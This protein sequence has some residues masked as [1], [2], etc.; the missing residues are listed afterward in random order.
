MTDWNQIEYF[1]A[2]D[3]ASD[4]HDVVV[5]NKLG[6]I[7]VDFRFEHSGP[8]WEQFKE[9][10]RPFLG[11]PVA[12]ETNNGPAVDQLLAG[13]WSVYPVN[14]QSAERYRDRKLPSGTKTDHFDG[15]SLADALRTDGRG[16]KALAA[17]DPLLVELRLLCHDE[18]A[19]IEQRTGLINQLRAALREYYPAALEAFEDWTLPS[20]W[21][22][23]LAFP[24]P[25]KLPTAGRRHWEKFLHTHKLW[26]TQTV[27]QRLEIFGRATAFSGSVPI[28]AAKSLLACSVAR[29]LQTL[30]TQLQSFRLRIQALFAQHPDHDLFGSLPGA[31]IKIAPRLLA[32]L[33]D[34]RQQF[35]D[36]QSLQC[37]AG[38]APMS[39]E[40][41]QIKKARLRQACNDFLRSTIH[42]W[43]NLSRRQCPWAQ[44]YYQAH[45]AKGKSHACALRCL[46]QR[47]LK[48]LWRMWQNKTCYSPELH[49]KNQLAHGSWVLQLI[50]PK[51]SQ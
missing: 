40:S 14:P 18:V 8:G 2:L 33:G 25:H 48:I 32:G 44:A 7:V 51:P 28:V 29:L 46:G 21:A 9:Q 27:E 23:I 17:Q 37:H 16:W 6:Q 39:F 13:D 4:H 5:V 1:A 22:F 26:R 20:A 3:W 34:N 30:E 41:G 36:A 11:A 42:L 31:G 35:P 38:T 50:T 15:W 47:W 24:T 49:Q 19:L 43:A 10:M 12:V 45:R